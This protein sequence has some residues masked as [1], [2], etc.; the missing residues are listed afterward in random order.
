[1]ATHWLVLIDFLVAAAAAAFCLLIGRRIGRRGRWAL[2]LVSAAAAGIMI[3]GVHEFQS[4]PRRVRKYTPFLA[5]RRDKDRRK[6][7][8]VY[9]VVDT[10]VCRIDGS[11]DRQLLPMDYTT[12][13]DLQWSPDG[14]WLACARASENERGM[15]IFIF[16]M[17]DDAAEPIRVT[18][19]ESDI[20]RRPTWSPDGTRIAYDYRS[21]MRSKVSEIRVVNIADGRIRV[22]TSGPSGYAYHAVWSPDGGTIYFLVKNNRRRDDIWAMDSSGEGEARQLTFTP[23]QSETEPAVSPDG[24]MVAYSVNRRAIHVMNADGSGQR[25]LVDRDSRGVKGRDPAWMPDGD[26]LLFTGFVRDLSKRRIYRL[27]MKTDELIELPW[28]TGR[29]FNPTPSPDG[30]QLAYLRTVRTKLRNVPPPP[31][32]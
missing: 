24:R 17:A 20:C 16:P 14:A 15:G 30:S 19:R 22:L 28:I 8:M 25:L 1:M 2:C 32:E 7:K 31:G 3:W 11:D 26:T 10:R 29:V 6:F 4:K 13:R 27:K 23:D 9:S 18:P 21:G 12:T 5:K